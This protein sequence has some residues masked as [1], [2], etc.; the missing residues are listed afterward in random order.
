MAPRGPAIVE[1]PPS[2]HLTPGWTRGKLVY[3]GL[4]FGVLLLRLVF[5][6]QKYEGACTAQSDILTERPS[7]ACFGERPRAKH[8]LASECGIPWALRAQAG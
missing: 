5:F 8:L 6:C 3:L 7:D 2:L 1:G 4:S